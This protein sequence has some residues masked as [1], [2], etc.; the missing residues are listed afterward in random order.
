MTNDV[1][2]DC[3]STQELTAVFP[4]KLPFDET[5]VSRSRGIFVLRN[6]GESWS[7]CDVGYPWSQPGFEHLDTASQLIALIRPVPL[8][9]GA[10]PLQPRFAFDLNLDALL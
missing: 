2:V 4:V 1:R 7:V 9:C 8:P 3:R 10:K 6:D 5:E